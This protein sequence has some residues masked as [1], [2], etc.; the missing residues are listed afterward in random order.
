M[1]QIA[2][3]RNAAWKIHNVP[4][5]KAIRNDRPRIESRSRLLAEYG[6]QVWI[7]IAVV[8]PSAHAAYMRQ[9]PGLQGGASL[10]GQALEIGKPP[11]VRVACAAGAL[12]NFSNLPAPQSGHFTCSPFLTRSSNSC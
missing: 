7:S 3:L 6:A 2:P 8:A 12:S 11:A 10:G 5:T 1:P 4:A 9:Q